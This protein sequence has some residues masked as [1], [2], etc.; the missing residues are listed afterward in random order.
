MIDALSNALVTP[1]KSRND[2]CPCGSGKRFKHCHGLATDTNASVTVP[3]SENA[4]EI[5]YAALAAQ[6]RGELA[7]AIALYRRSL[8]IEPDNSDAL[9]MLGVALMQHFEPLPSLEFIKK[10]A[11]LTGWQ[12]PAMRH[13]FGWALSVLM[14]ARAPANMGARADLVAQARRA[15]ASMP[16]FPRKKVAILALCHSRV[17]FETLLSHLSIQSRQPDAVIVLLPGSEC[18]EQLRDDLIVVHPSE[19]PHSALSIAAALRLIRSDYV[20]LIDGAALYSPSRLEQMADALQNNG[21]QWGFS[22]VDLHERQLHPM[23]DGAPPMLAELNGLDRLQHRARMGELFVERPGLPITLSNLMFEHGLL[24]EVLG[25]PLSS[26][27]TLLGVSLAAVWLAEPYF[28]NASTLQIRRH[29]LDERHRECQTDVCQTMMRAFVERMINSSSAPNPLAPHFSGDGVDVLKRA[30]RGGL[31]SKLDKSQLLR[32]ANFTQNVADTQPLIAEGIEFIGFARAE[33]GLGENLRSLV[34]ATATSAL[35][36][37]VSVADVDIDSG[38][39]N[40]DSSVESFMDGRMFRTRVVCVNPDMLGEAFHHDGF[41]RY[42]DAYRVGLWFW[43]L[44]RL[45]TMWVEHAKLVDEIWVGSDF[46]AEAVRRSVQDRAVTKI[47]IPVVASLPD[48]AYS[49]LEFG[50]RDE[51]CLFMFSFAYGSFATR[52]NPEAVIHAFRRAFPI[53]NEDAQLLVKTSQSELYP[54]LRDALV[55]MATGDS[56][57]KFIN[58]YLSRAEVTGLQSTIDCYVSLHRSEGLGL[59]LAECMVAG[60]P[61]IATAYSGNLEFMNEENSFLVDYR[62]VPVRAGEYPD[63]EGQVWADASVDHA[64]IHMRTVYTDRARAAQIGMAAK[65]HLEQHFNDHVIGQAIVARY[66]AIQALR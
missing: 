38:I 62:L 2:P 7:D 12:I 47:R 60:K 25:D 5:A 56:R 29:V 46:V 53:G 36:A 16:G 20:Q 49:R 8:E 64:A 39:R 54:Q 42:Q 6:Q 22:K 11:D 3:P 37:S 45:P 18:T 63:F 1:P 65:S 66:H 9:H 13:N 10:A 15:R 30:L 17:Q 34:R 43:E 55:A 59:G 48:R 52:K 50:L 27:P 28:V 24:M 32:I 58:G 40:S 51:C 23:Q 61:T 14:S 35:G 21:A 19:L 4:L 26:P 44:E 33:S 31:G 57:I 41:G